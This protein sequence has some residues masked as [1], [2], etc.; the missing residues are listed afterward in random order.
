MNWESHVAEFKVSYNC[1][2]CIPEYID[3]ILPIYYYDITAAFSDMAAVIREED[4]GLPI[5]QVMNRYIYEDYYES[6]MDEW[7]GFDEEDIT[8]FVP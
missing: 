4:I 3:S 5:W 6:F 7:H 1:E 8:P 2:S